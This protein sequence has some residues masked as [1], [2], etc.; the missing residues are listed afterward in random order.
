MPAGAFATVIVAEALLGR[1]N[2]LVMIVNNGMG[3]FG[4]AA[5]LAIMA[6][7]CAPPRPSLFSRDASK[8]LAG[9]T[10]LY[11]AANAASL[12]HRRRCSTIRASGWSLKTELYLKRLPDAIYVA[13]AE[14]LFYLQMELDKLLVLAIGG[15][16][17]RRHLRHHHAAGR[18]DG[19]PD[20][21]LLDDAG[22]KA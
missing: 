21:R 13:G 19:D 8:R 5:A 7:R 6:R 11:I 20:P 22:A 16:A 10:W 18:P 3:R 14:V 2:E 17:A 9:W 15:A 12:R 4:R 1:P